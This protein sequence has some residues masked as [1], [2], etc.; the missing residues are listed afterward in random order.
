MM[1]TKHFDPRFLMP[2][3]PVFAIA[4]AGYCA[5]LSG[6]ARVFALATLA[7]ADLSAAQTAISATR[8]TVPWAAARLFQ[9]LESEYGASRVAV[10]GSCRDWNICNL[11]LVNERRNVRHRCAFVAD[12]SRGDPPTRDIDAVVVADRRDIEGR[13]NPAFLRGYDSVEP[14]L[15]ALGFRPITPATGHAGDIH[16]RA[17]V[18]S[19]LFSRANSESRDARRR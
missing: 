10:I 17:Y 13:T 2:L 7:F 15:G 1:F 3:F 9:E 12:L 4:L 6:A 16:M 8:T 18:R 11:L 19:E 14:R 5:R